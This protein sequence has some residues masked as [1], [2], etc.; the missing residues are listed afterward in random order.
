MKSGIGR[1]I[2]IIITLLSC[3]L[4][5][6]VSVLLDSESKVTASGATPGILDFGIKKA[7]AAKSSSSEFHV[8]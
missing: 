3:T 1:Y 4:N 7:D 5:A 8:V 2:F 6:Q